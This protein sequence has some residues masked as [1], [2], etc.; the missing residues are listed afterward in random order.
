VFLPD[1]ERIVDARLGARIS[2]LREE[3]LDGFDAIFSRLDRLETEY[4][5]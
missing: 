5:R 3:M 4:Q 1:L 2:P